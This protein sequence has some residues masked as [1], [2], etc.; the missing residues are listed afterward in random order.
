MCLNYKTY[1]IA[2]TPPLVHSQHSTRH[3]ATSVYRV[4]DKNDPYAALPKFL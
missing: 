2:T 1:T 4:S 3:H